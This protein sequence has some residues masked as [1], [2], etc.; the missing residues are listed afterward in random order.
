MIRHFCNFIGWSQ[1]SNSSP[2]DIK[3]KFV[4]LIP[5][6]LARP[7]VTTKT[8]STLVG[9]GRDLRSRS[10]ATWAVYYRF[11]H[12]RGRKGKCTEARCIHTLDLN[13]V[14]FGKQ[15]GGRRAEWWPY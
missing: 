13:T 11:L 8:W 10:G 4:L 5:K 1:S 3:A 9:R 14:L 12:E 2:V 7:L 6:L 15:N